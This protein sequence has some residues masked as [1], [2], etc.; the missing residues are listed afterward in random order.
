V[1]EQLVG[2]KESKV[3]PVRAILACWSCRGVCL[4]IVN[5]AVDRDELSISGPGRL[6]YRERTPEPIERKVGRLVVEAALLGQLG[7][8]LRIVQPVA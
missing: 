3:V 7:F 2:H 8:E 5:S 4:L 6:T 1:I